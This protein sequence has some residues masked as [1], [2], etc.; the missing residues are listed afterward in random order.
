MGWARWCCFCDQCCVGS[1]E[2]TNKND[3]QLSHLLC[4]EK[5]VQEIRSMYSCLKSMDGK[6]ADSLQDNDIFAW[7]CTPKVVCRICFCHFKYSHETLRLFHL[8][9]RV[10]RKELFNCYFSDFLCCTLTPRL[11]RQQWTWTWTQE[12]A[13]SWQ[14]PQSSQKRCITQHISHWEDMNSNSIQKLY[15]LCSLMTRVKQWGGRSDII[16][17]WKIFHSEIFLITLSYAVD[18]G[19]NLECCRQLHKLNLQSPA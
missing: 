6:V 10:Q 14:V 11:L 12:F 7:R 2:E 3:H 17:H 9:W 13:A 18:R 19:R 8:C 1:C 5:S 4:S 15:W 16:W